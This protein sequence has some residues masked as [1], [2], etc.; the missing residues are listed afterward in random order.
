MQLISQREKSSHWNTNFAVLR[1]KILAGK[2]VPKFTV[3]PE[4]STTL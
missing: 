4:S 3:I 2:T 1:M